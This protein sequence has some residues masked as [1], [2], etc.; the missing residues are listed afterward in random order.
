MYP[1]IRN[2]FP[3][4][5]TASL[6][7]TYPAREGIIASTQALGGNRRHTMRMGK[8]L[9]FRLAILLGSAWLLAGCYTV[10]R[11]PTTELTQAHGGDSQYGDC[12][13]CHD[14]GFDQPLLRDPYGYTNLA[15]WS[16]YGC[17]WWLPD[18][19]VGYGYAP[20]GGSGGGSY[21][22]PDEVDENGRAVGSRGGVNELPSRL[23]GV[24][25]PSSGGTGAPGTNLRPSEE[26]SG[27]SSS[28]STP[29][30]QE[31]R[32]MKRP[33]EKAPAPAAP[34]PSDKP[35]DEGKKDSQ[36]TRDDKS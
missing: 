12:A 6:G 21:G 33:A 25:P 2:R 29:G 11:H 16:Y 30:Q 22:R 35:K 20:G 32:E 17:P 23:P 27:N 36:K 1:G 15:F 13:S 9:N 26:G 4:A 7:A 31:G 14:Q 24:N 18:C 28:P 10:L 3:L 19:G 5:K 8:Q 34:P